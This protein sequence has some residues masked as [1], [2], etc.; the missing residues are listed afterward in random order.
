VAA[1]LP[2]GQRGEGSLH[3]AALDARG[4]DG[5]RHR[6]CTGTERDFLVLVPETGAGAKEQHLHVARR[7]T[8]RACDLGRAEAADL[9]H[10][11]GSAVRGGQ[12]LQGRPHGVLILR[13]QGHGL[14]GA[15]ARRIGMRLRHRLGQ[16]DVGLPAALAQRRHG[17]IRGDA[18]D[19][20]AESLGLAQR[21]EGA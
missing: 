12:S 16:F 9:A 1:P 20:G 11:Q 4:L 14:G 18:R 13:G 3:A 2:A 10:D 19:P 6:R 21:R 8:K 15:P 7:R 17:R 5:G